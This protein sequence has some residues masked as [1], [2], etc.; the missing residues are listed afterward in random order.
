MALCCR[1]N[2]IIDDFE[3]ENESITLDKYKIIEDP[4]EPVIEF[5]NS[6]FHTK[7]NIF[8]YKNKEYITKH[9]KWIDIQSFKLYYMN[10]NIQCI[11][12]K[13]KNTKSTNKLILFSQGSNTNLGSALPFLLG[14][15][16]YLKM[17]ILTYEYFEKNEEKQCNSD[18]NILFAYLNKITT[19]SEI[20]LMGQSIGNIINMNIII[21]KINKRLNKIKSFIMISPTWKFSYVSEN[22]RNKR[23][24][25]KRLTK[26]LDTFFSVVNQQ[27]INIFLIHGKKDYFVKYYLTLSLSQ[28]IENLTVWYPKDGNHYGIVNECRTK[29]LSKIKKYLNNGYSLPSSNKNKIDE[30][31]QSMEFYNESLE[32]SDVIDTSDI[33]NN[34]NFIYLTDF[35]KEEYVIE[36]ADIIYNANKYNSKDNCDNYDT[37][38]FKGGDLVPSFKDNNNKNRLLSIDQQEDNNSIFSFTKK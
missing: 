6:N 5:K 2:Q 3:E 21:S 13:N 26:Y 33:T 19:I 8:I 38:S 34:S 7:K 29:L 36:D 16:N 15:S 17:N 23:G 14:L 28:R 31:N 11:H 27:K 22:L 24:G 35:E 37:I 12:I 10:R 18:I 30:K 20:V 4:K 32:K 1:R 25:I 9:M